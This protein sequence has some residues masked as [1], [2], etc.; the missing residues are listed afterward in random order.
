M[1]K[2]FLDIYIAWVC[3]PLVSSGFNRIT[4]LRH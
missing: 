1:T 2:T 3:L 4:D